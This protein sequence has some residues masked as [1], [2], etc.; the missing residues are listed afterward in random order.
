MTP[1]DTSAEAASRPSPYE[2]V[3]G[4]AAVRRITDRFYDIM[5]STPEAARI[6]ALHADDLSAVRERLFEFLSGWLGGPPLYF[7][8]PDHKCIMSAHRPFA[9]GATERDEWM[10][11]M[12]RALSECGVPA[13]VQTLLDA[14]FLRLAEAFRNR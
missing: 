1:I 5:D 6:R 2:I 14:A 8:R 3:G 4:E 13:D 12:R 9:I 11:C 7:Q 10:T